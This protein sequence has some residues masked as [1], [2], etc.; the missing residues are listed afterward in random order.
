M[1]PSAEPGLCRVAAGSP[2]TGLRGL[3]G[4]LTAA[5]NAR[6]RPWEPQ[7]A[8]HCSAVGIPSSRVD[9]SE[10]RDQNA[11]GRVSFIN[12]RKQ[13]SPPPYPS[14]PTNG[15]RQLLCTLLCCRAPGS[16]KFICQSSRKIVFSWCNRLR[17][18]LW[19]GWLF[20]PQRWGW[21][22]GQQT[23]GGCLASQQSLL[24]GS[25]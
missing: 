16:K 5:N 4:R 18:L 23:D 8:L 1:T 25:T 12:G 2:L 13:T 10:V 14:N 22:P 3:N 9:L 7:P 19:D 21:G 6:R 15:P 17:S 20:K 11:T 24:Q